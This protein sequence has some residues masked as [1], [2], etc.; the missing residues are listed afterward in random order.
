MQRGNW[1]SL[2]GDIV[3]VIHHGGHVCWMLAPVLNVFGE[4]EGG[5][6]CPTADDAGH[7]DVHG[8]VAIVPGR[9]EGDRFLG[10]VSGDGS[11]IGRESIDAVLVGNQMLHLVG[12]ENR[13]LGRMGHPGSRMCGQDC[14]EEIEQ[15][16]GV[17]GAW[18]EEQGAHAGMPRDV[19]VDI[20]VEMALHRGH[21]GC[22]EGLPG[23]HGEC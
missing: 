8:H 5:M 20:R 17:L 6:Q 4:H 1:T 3:L 13:I 10:E 11:D 19:G 16:I 7:G 18:T 15:D 12:D 23:S 21:G 22:G 14:L 9:P 2:S